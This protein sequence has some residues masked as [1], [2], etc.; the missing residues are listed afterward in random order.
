M[1]AR[2]PDNPHASSEFAGNAFEE[3]GPELHRFLMRRT[4]C[5]QTAHD[6]AQDAYLRFVLVARREHIRNAQAF[7][8]QLA[9]NLVYEF[10]MRERNSRV[11]FDSNLLET[12]DHLSAPAT[13]ADPLDQLA[14]ADQL[15]RLLRPLPKAYRAVLLLR[16]RDGLSPAEIAQRL[17]FTR[18]TVYDYLT[19]ALAMIRENRQD[20]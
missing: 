17:G 20:R 6:L 11:V 19:R 14:S 1:N 5:T 3:Y 12:V 16:K 7:L 4:G 2:S 10:R 18:K 13:E 15:E 8:Y 9:S